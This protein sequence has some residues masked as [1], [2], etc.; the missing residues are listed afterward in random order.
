MGL[1]RVARGDSAPL[2]AIVS[3]E[4]ARHL[5]AAGPMRWDRHM[6]RSCSFGRG[7]MTQLGS[8]MFGP[9]WS[10]TAFG[11]AGLSGMTTVACD[12]ERRTPLLQAEYETWQRRQPG[13]PSARTIVRLCGTWADA[14]DAAD[15]SSTRKPCATRNRSTFIPFSPR[16]PGASPRPG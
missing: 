12:P 8:H 9:G 16:R 13:H 11:Q 14:L 4:V 6:Q 2:A 7:F 3:P 5:T 1:G 15:I 10:D